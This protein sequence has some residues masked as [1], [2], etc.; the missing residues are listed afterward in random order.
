M[1]LTYYRILLDRINHELK[2]GRSVNNFDN[3]V[4]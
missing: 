4:L 2:L 3:I 1:L